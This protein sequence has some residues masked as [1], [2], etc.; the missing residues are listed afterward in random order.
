MKVCYNPI[1]VAE[2]PPIMLNFIDTVISRE[3]SNENECGLL[4]LNAMTPFNAIPPLSI[5][6]AQISRIPKLFS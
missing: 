6:Y 4:S 1:R 2:E 5:F 3:Q